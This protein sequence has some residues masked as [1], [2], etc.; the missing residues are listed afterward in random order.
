MVMEYDCQPRSWKGRLDGWRW[1]GFLRAEFGQVE[2]NP[3]V[4]EPEAHLCKGTG[5]VEWDYVED[6]KE[7]EE[8]GWEGDAEVKEGHFV[9]KKPSD[10]AAD[11]EE[12][13]EC[14]VDHSEGP[15]LS[16]C[17]WESVCREIE[18]FE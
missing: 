11:V 15:T 18:E 2:I 13:E 8:G 14:V 16:Q 10:P 7:E 1:V 6:E 12:R 3:F 9:L 4:L 17:S 5:G